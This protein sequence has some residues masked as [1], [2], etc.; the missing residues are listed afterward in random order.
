MHHQPRL[1][2][3]E[4]IFRMWL[5]WVMA[6]GS[7][8]LLA[9]LSLWIRHLWMPFVAFGLEL[10]LFI[11]IK[12][13]RSKMFPICH[14]MP[15]VATRIMFWSAI[16]MLIIN[17]LYSRWLV[18]HVFDVE[19]INH[20]IPFITQLI[21]GPITIVVCL[22]AVLKDYNL[23]FC[24]DCKMSHGSPA[25]RG[26]LGVLFSQEG[27][28]QVH[29]ML[30]ISICATVAS[31]LYYWLAYNNSSLTPLDKYVYVWCPTLLFV[32]SLLYTA[33]R[34]MGLWKYYERNI[35]GSA[36]RAGRN[37]RIRYLMIYDNYIGLHVPDP[38]KESIM[39]GD[40]K[41][42]TPA[43]L[44]TQF[45][46]NV[47]VAEAQLYF[48]QL[49]GVADADVRLLYTTLSGN[50]DCNI[51]HFIVY[52]SEDNKAAYIHRNED[53][54]WFT[55]YEASRLINK[56]KTSPLLSAELVRIYTM[57]QAW[58]T[59]DENGKRKYA[60]KHYTPTFRFRDLHKWD[61]DYNNPK[62][63]FIADNNEDVRFY[64]LRK[65]W[66]K[67]INGIGDI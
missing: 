47:P 10:L 53:V 27:K 17:G 28:F 14:L 42:D 20:E 35:E 32:A 55:I 66:R 4:G 52:L 15:F 13:N 65:F 50:A 46:A 63:L 40:A 25:E 36:K 48:K 54:H 37:T 26:F 31:W 30:G 43:S 58:K 21:V 3:S 9:I 6:S 24:R 8:T 22:W 5:N 59:Y 38:E 19:S 2:N 57:A 51:F 18:T 7:L 61:I 11:S 45:K 62:W 1:E 16:T 12:H 67:Y 29:L 39:P 56:G 44:V 64:R 41:I 34:Y 60:I 33:V 23:A 49:T